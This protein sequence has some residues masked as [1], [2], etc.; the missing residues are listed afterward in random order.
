MKF[1][2]YNF[3]GKKSKSGFSLIEMIVA[4]T[5][6]IIAMLIIVGALISLNNA[7]RKARSVRLVVD[8]VDAAIDSMSRNIRMGSEF[9]CGCEVDPAQYSVLKDC[10]APMDA[11][12]G[13]GDACFAFQSQRGEKIVYQL[14]SGHIQRSNDGGATFLDLTAPEITINS[15]RFF[16]YGT[17]INEDQ[18][19]VTMLI[20]G[21]AQL[22]TKTST[23]FDIQTTIGARTPHYSP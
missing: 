2:K 1:F 14:T 10:D 22:T 4:T 16:V 19:V 18:P 7:A 8:N 13:G 20:R 17:T 6:F 11:Q 15:L 21:V 5:I 3:V 12:G 9:H 23:D